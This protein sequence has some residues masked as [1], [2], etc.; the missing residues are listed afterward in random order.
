MSP[1]PP[2]AANARPA[3]VRTG[4]STA[5]PAIQWKC[6]S[7]HGT[8][9]ANWRDA[10]ASYHACD[11]C[12]G[13]GNAVPRV[14]H[15]LVTRACSHG[16]WVRSAVKAIV[17]CLQCGAETPS[18]TADR[19]TMS[20]ELFDA[21][22]TLGEALHGGDG[23]SV[24][25]LAKEAALELKTLRA[26]VTEEREWVVEYLQRRSE[27]YR[28]FAHTSKDGA[29][30]VS[31]RRASLVATMLANE[32]G[33]LA[34]KISI[35]HHER[36][37]PTVTSE[38]VTATADFDAARAVATADMSVV[39]ALVKELDQAY[40]RAYGPNTVTDDGARG[41]WSQ[42]RLVLEREAELRAKVEAYA[43]AEE[44]GFNAQG[45]HDRIDAL[46]DAI[47]KRPVVR[48]VEGGPMGSSTSCTTTTRTCTCRRTS[49]TARARS[50]DSSPNS[51]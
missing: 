15:P 39:S 1:Q 49:T 18:E 16:P 7:C 30:S 20:Q 3:E 34:E 17:V 29:R 41:R 12:G 33:I 45:L 38:Q 47:E 43:R 27:G 28:G 25:V 42:A 26:K 37:T 4:P 22:V 50:S 48:P 8:G 14:A 40:H 44:V 11:A 35:G 21:G 24:P 36:A 5:D 51:T 32:C 9:D 19:Q 13:S 46:H 10:Q 23:K 31:A 2:P 6:P